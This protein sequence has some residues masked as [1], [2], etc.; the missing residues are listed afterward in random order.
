MSNY[1]KK[2]KLKIILT[3]GFAIQ[4]VIVK[5]FFLFKKSEIEEDRKNVSF[6][7]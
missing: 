3:C 2:Y 5:Q 4:S 7:I 6:F 1:L